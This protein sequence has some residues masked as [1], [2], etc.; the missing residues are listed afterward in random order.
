MINRLFRFIIVYTRFVIFG[1]NASLEDEIFAQETSS[2]FGARSKERKKSP[3]VPIL[4]P[5]F[6]EIVVQNSLEIPGKNHS[7]ETQKSHFSHFQKA[8]KSLPKV[9]ILKIL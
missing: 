2:S 3:A 6:R 5:F 4:Q 9:Q 7:E 1:L 8:S